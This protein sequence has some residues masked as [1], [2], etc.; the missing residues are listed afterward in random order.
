MWW[1]S[2]RIRVER[3]NCCDDLAVSLCG[4]PVTYAAALADLEELRARQ[5]DSLV[6]AATGGSLLERVRRLLGAPSHAGRAPGLAR[7]SAAMLVIVGIAAGAVGRDIVVADAA[8]PSAIGSRHPG[9]DRRVRPAR[10]IVTCR[11]AGSAEAPPPP[12][13]Q[14]IE[15]DELA[16]SRALAATHRMTGVRGRPRRRRASN[17]S[18]MRH[19]GRSSWPRASDSRRVSALRRRR[20]S[21]RRACGQ[22]RG[23]G[24]RRRPRGRRERRERGA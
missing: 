21:A 5:A 3:E 23:S 10:A 20:V 14:A 22:L 7:R 4:D 6:L 19:A 8:T 11:A 12:I 2:R 15:A 17:G 24:G 1:L 18:R 9:D 16:A 13:E